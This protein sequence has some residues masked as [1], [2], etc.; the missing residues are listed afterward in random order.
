MIAFF[1]QMLESRRW[2]ARFGAINGIL[3]MVELRQSRQSEEVDTFLWEFILTK[4]FPELL[5]DSEFRVRNQLATLLKAIISSDS[6]VKGIQNF[7]RM[8]DIILGNIQA[9][10]ERDS[11]ADASGALT[12]LSSG[13]VV[14]VRP[15]IGPD[16][17]SGKTMHDSE[18]WKSLETS[19]RNLQHLIEAIGPSLY[20]FDLS[21]ILEVVVKAIAHLNRFVREI[22]YFVINAIFETSVGI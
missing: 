10:F 22:A 4:A 7:D 14:S 12:T 8:K 16:S 1:K 2:E 6:S 11:S 21:I 19:M 3:A 15:L 5:V 18:G 9:T 20:E 13:K 17:E